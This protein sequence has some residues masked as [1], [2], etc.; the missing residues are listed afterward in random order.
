M[1]FYNELS[2]AAGYEVI[3]DRDLYLVENLDHKEKVAANKK[4]GDEVKI[5][6]EESLGHD[7]FSIDLGAD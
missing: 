5:E 7:D 1:I 3:E 4:D 2:W 6:K